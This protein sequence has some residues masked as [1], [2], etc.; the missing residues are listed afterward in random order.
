[1]QQYSQLCEFS[2][3]SKLSR[4]FYVYVLPMFCL[5]VRHL[6]KLSRFDFTDCTFGYVLENSLYNK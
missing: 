2:A 5:F 6:A 1:M 3:V 4:V